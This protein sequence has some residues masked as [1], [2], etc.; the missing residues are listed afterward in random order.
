MGLLKKIFKFYEPP[1]C[2]GRTEE[3]IKGLHDD[4]EIT[5][6]LSFSF[7]RQGDYTFKV[8]EE[9]G[10]YHVESSGMSRFGRDGTEFVLDYM[11]DGKLVEKLREIC[12]KYELSKDNGHTIHVAGL[13][14]CGGETI[15]VRFK[16][17]DRIYRSSNQ[18][19][20]VPKDAFHEIFDAFRSDAKKHNFDFTTDK[21]MINYDDADYTYLQGT[22][23][24]THFGKHVYVEFI[25][26]N[27]TI[28]IDGKTTDKCKWQ[29]VDGRVI[30]DN[31][32]KYPKFNGMSCMTKYMANGLTAHFYENKSS[33]TASLMRV[34]E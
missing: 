29:V 27:V 5:E 10:M 7:E 18:G 15:D 8:S 32:E 19:S 28:M 11:T 21:S 22:W 13:P 24:G 20:M 3:Y 25:G 33:S 26:E 16:S 2:G 12:I 34:K 31:G 6:I 30:P 4:I 17:G 23:T 9:D 14:P 1:V